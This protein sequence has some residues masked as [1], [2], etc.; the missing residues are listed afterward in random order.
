MHLLYKE[1][2][3]IDAHTIY[4]KYPMYFLVKIHRGTPKN[5]LKCGSSTIPK[6]PYG[7][8]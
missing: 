6:C 8:T 5:P 3:I 1:N 7:S 4:S 2:F